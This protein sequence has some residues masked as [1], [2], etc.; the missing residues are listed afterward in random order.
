MMDDKSIK[1]L[2]TT[3]LSILYNLSSSFDKI[4]QNLEK[5]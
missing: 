5:I 2:Y 3:Q 1:L 4:H